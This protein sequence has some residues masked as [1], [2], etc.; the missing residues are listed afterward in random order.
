[1]KQHNFKSYFAEFLGTFILVFFGCGTAIVTGGEVVPT[2]LAFGLAIVVIA[3]SVGRISGGHVNPAVSL[4]MVLDRRLNIAYFVKYCIAQILG[5]LLASGL[6]TVLD[7]GEGFGTNTF[8]SFGG[9]STFLFEI[10]IT[11]FFILVILFVTDNKGTSNVSG[12]IIGLT[13]TFVHLI[14]I[15]LDGTSVNPARSLGP[16]FFEAL[17]GRNFIPSQE[18]WVFIFAPLIGAILATRI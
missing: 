12:L 8:D 14:G 13:L 7:V 15:P 17:V 1:M 4:A 18:L 16:A 6:L 5:A 2:A 10:I 11:A 3:Y 9:P